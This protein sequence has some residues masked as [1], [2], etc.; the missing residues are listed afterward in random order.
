MDILYLYHSADTVV[1]QTT[2]HNDPIRSSFIFEYQAMLFVSLP[3][4][5][6]GAL[7]LL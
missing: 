4:S 1:S 6:Y 3:L 7:V 5:A 2:S